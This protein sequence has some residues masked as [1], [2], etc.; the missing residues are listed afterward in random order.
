MEDTLVDRLPVYPLLTV[1]CLVFLCNTLFSDFSFLLTTKIPPFYYKRV[2]I[3][4]LLRCFE[5]YLIVCLIISHC[6]NFNAFVSYL[7]AKS[8]ASRGWA[9]NTKGWGCW[10]WNQREWWRCQPN[11][12]PA[13]DASQTCALLKD[14]PMHVQKVEL[15][16]GTFS[17]RCVEPWG[18]L[19]KLIRKRSF[20]RLRQEDPRFEVSLIFLVSEILSQKNKKQNST[21]C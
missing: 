4:V 19:A 14:Q 16:L 3:P 20:R 11:L 18:Y 15:F 5:C 10:E 2:I 1:A 12:C 17:Y 8:D 9:G 13:E 21:D 6:V 7:V